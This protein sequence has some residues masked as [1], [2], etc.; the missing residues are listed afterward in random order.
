MREGESRDSVQKGDSNAILNS[1][2]IKEKTVKRKSNPHKS[3]AKSPCKKVKT[4]PRKLGQSKK[5]TPKKSS[6]SRSNQDG[7]HSLVAVVQVHRSIKQTAVSF[8]E[9]GNVV[10]METEGMNTEF[11]SGEEDTEES[12][13]ESEEE[14]GSDSEAEGD[15][16]VNTSS[17]NSSKEKDL[18]GP[19]KNELSEGE[20][21]RKERRRSTSRSRKL[22]RQSREEKEDRIVNKAVAKLQKIME[23]SVANMGQQRDCEGKAVKEANS[24]SEITIYKRAVQ[25]AQRTRAEEAN[26]NQQVKKLRISTSSEEAEVDTSDE[27][28]NSQI[29]DD[30]DSRVIADFIAESREREHDNRD[31]DRGWYVWREERFSRDRR[32][33]SPSEPRPSCSHDGRE[34]RD[35]DRDRDPGYQQS[36]SRQ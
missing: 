19:T 31:R 8:E 28:I 7:E 36:V 4:L 3:P 18:E 32:Y 34:D 24:G 29:Y 2:K 9:D 26:I 25:P 12:T 15:T 21:E 27:L 16:G 11:M 6:E 20:M 10:D 13:E 35:R 5:L 17:H 30:Q 14:D 1:P 23:M 22:K 33:R